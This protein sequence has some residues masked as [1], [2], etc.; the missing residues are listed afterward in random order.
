[1]P[2]L[3]DSWH[4]RAIHPGRFTRVLDAV[5]AIAPP[6]AERLLDVGTGDGS[7]AVEIGKRVGAKDVQGVDVL[8]RPRTVIPVHH[9]DGLTLPRPDASAD[10]VTIIDVLHHAA[11]PR[12]L[13]AE[14][15]RVAG[16]SGAVV[17]KEH[18][19]FGAWS[20]GV[21]WAM[22]VVGNAAAGV[23]VTAGYFSPKQ[24]KELVRAAGG[25]IEEIEWPLEIHGAPWRW[26]AK[27]EYQFACRLV[28]A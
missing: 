7:L 10:L 26:I 22:D 16:S 19:A 18:Y 12:R 11:D 1:M 21:L 5:T 3:L 9:F 17:V 13:L 28:R 6:R 24:W 8:I 14:A 4:E 20:R 15:L 25:R 23:A 27:S 2:S